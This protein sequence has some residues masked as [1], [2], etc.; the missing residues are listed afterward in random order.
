M[1]KGNTRIKEVTET[2][3]DIPANERQWLAAV[4]NDVVYTVAN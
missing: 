1:R 3:Y 4:K 2:Y